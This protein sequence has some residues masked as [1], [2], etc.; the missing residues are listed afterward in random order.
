MSVLEPTHF[1][2]WPLASR[3]GVARVFGGAVAPAGFARFAAAGGQFHL[4]LNVQP[5]HTYALE[6]SGDLVH[7]TRVTTHTPLTP[8]WEFTDTAM[9]GTSAKFYRV[10]EITP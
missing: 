10:R 3:S 9:A 5:G 4:T 1:T 8:M 6:A 2:M 7:W